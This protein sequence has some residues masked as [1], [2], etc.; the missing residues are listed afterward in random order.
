MDRTD[1]QSA[2]MRNISCMFLKHGLEYQLYGT[3]R[4]NL[5]SQVSQYR[6]DVALGAIRSEPFSEVSTII[7]VINW[8]SRG[9]K[10][11]VREEDEVESGF[12]L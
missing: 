1:V 5:M 10:E 9:N 8:D 2:E 6:I 4:C 11:L 12:C 3:K 7:L